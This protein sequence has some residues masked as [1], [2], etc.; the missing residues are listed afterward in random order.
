MLNFISVISALIVCVGI[1][2]LLIK[3]KEYEFIEKEIK[4]KSNKEELGRIGEEE[5]SNVLNTLPKSDYVVINNLLYLYNNS[6]HQIDHVVV[7]NYGIF[8]IETKNYSGRIYG[9]DNYNTWVQY[10]GKNKYKMLNPVLQNYGHLKALESI[11]PEYKDYFVSIVCFTNKS[12]LSV[13]SK[14]IVINLSELLSTIQNYETEILLQD[15]NE[16]SQKLKDLCLNIQGAEEHHI[17]N[18]RKLRK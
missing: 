4:S 8:I 14:N 18:I 3:V 6:T 5:V 13:K 11:I 16:V 15:I 7:S 2:V 17:D 9:S 12:K 10:L 1:I